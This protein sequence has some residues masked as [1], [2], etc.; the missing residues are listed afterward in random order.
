MASITKVATGYRAQVYVKG[1]RDS[2]IRRTKRE[3]EIWAAQ[4]TIE[5]R[6]EVEKAPGERHTLGAAIDKYVQEVVP[7]KR[8]QS[9]EEIRFEAMKRE[10]PIHLPIA[11]VTPEILGEW[12]DKMLARGLS[13]GSALRYMGQ[14][15]SMLETARREW[16]WIPTNP[17]HDV[18]KPKEPPH[19]TVTFNRAQI[20]G[21]LIGFGYSPIKPVSTIMQS[22]AVAFLLAL[23]SGM[24]AGEICGLQWRYLHDGYC[25]LPVT[26]TKARDVPLTDKAMRLV[27]KMEG[28][29]K[30][31]VFGIKSHSLDALFRKVRDRQGMYGFRFHDSR[32]TAATWMVQS[33]KVDVLT[34]CKIFGW[35][36]TAQALTYFN[37]KASDIAKQ[38]SARPRRDQSQQ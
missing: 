5:L 6:D 14:L 10:L 29:D 7:I 26:K 35:S 31:L 33:G 27:R 9:K 11:K 19:R 25:H 22:C 15:S 36:N 20:K 1:K 2:A 16:R 23:R 8:G 12:R 32:H 38:L 18:R 34:L 13:P 24:R 30:V 4:R 21:M 17:M 28:F 3:A 37:P